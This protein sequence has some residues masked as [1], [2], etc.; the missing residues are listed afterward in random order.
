[1]LNYY[2]LDENLLRSATVN[3]LSKAYIYL[4][5]HIRGAYLNNDV[6]STYAVDGGLNIRNMHVPVC[7]E[8]ESYEGVDSLSIP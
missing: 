1:M 4:F 8:V 7:A 6:T 5:A 2:P 3:A